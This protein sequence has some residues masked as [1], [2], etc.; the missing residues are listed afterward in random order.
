MDR[1]LLTTVEN[2]A[3]CDTPPSRIEIDNCAIALLQLFVQVRG[4]WRSWLVKKWQWNQQHRHQ[5]RLYD[6]LESGRG[7]CCWKGPGLL[8][9][10]QA[11]NIDHDDEWSAATPVPLVKL[12]SPILALSVA[13][14]LSLLYAC[15]DFLSWLVWLIQFDEIRFQSSHH[16]ACFASSLVSSS[17]YSIIHQDAERIRRKRRPLRPTKVLLH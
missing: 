6:T 12:K 2:N 10:V 8:E 7:F 9:A 14:Y 4:P 1:K 5:S 3:P 16:V 17:D 15:H 11:N 13:L